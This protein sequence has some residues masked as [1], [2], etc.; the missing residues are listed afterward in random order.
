MPKFNPGLLHG[1]RSGLEE[2]VAKQLKDA[3]IDAGYETEK[4]G[5]LK[6][7]RLSKYT[8]DFMLPNGIVIETKGRFLT[9]DRQKHILIKQQHPDLDI[10]FVFSNSR[11]RISKNSKTTYALWCEKH[12]F[13]YS[14]KWIPEAWLKEAP[15]PTRFDALKAASPDNKNK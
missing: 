6:P 1:Y 3:G 9:A 13:Q 14:D 7:A 12:G 5:Y 10:R 8:P 4:V 2:Q 15:Q 11:G